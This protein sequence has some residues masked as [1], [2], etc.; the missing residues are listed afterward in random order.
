[1]MDSNHIHKSV[2]NL[3]KNENEFDDI[4]IYFR[5]QPYPYLLVPTSILNRYPTTV[6]FCKTN[7]SSEFSVTMVKK[8]FHRTVISHEIVV[9]IILGQS[10]LNQTIES[11]SLYSNNSY[12]P[13]LF[14]VESLSNV[15]EIF[16]V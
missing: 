1:M 12:Q 2:F 8:L 15:Q 11:A 10:K 9:L 5:H 3:H 16:F 6:A 13:Y 4:L 7:A 14:W